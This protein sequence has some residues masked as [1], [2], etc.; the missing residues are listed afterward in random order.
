M[1]LVVGLLLPAT[2]HPQ[3]RPGAAPADSGSRATIDTVIILRQDLF[4]D[5]DEAGNAFF[6]FFN[7]LHTTTRPFVIERELLLGAG[8]P[9]DSLLAAES[10]RN[11]RRLGLFRSVR[12]DTGQV[13][14]RRALIVRTRDAWSL[15]PRATARI[16]ADGTLTGS[17]G[18]TETNLA[19][20]GNRLRVWYVREADRDGL[21]L[22]ASANRVGASQI[23]A[24]AAW[25]NLSD[26]DILRWAVARPFRSFSD[27]WSLHY[28]GRSF[29]GRV[30]QFRRES[31][32]ELETTE[33]RRHAFVNQAFATYAPV[34]NARE[35]VRVGASF[36]IRSEKYLKVE[37]PALDVDSIFAAV[38]D[39]V[40]GLIGGFVE[41]R[42]A[43]FARVRQFNGFS[44]EDQDLSDRAFMSLKLA[45]E[46][47]GYSST[48]VG[49]R[50]FLG[51]GTRVGR[52]ILKGVIDGS[53]LFNSAGL[54]SGLVVATATAAIRQSEHNTTFFQASG[55]LQESPRPGR[56]FDLGFERL[57]RLWGAHAFVGT[58]TFR[59]TVE[60]R[61]FALDN[62]LDLVGLGF[63]GF[64][65]YGGAWYPDQESRLGGNTGVS[66]FI[67]SPLGSFA[68]VS[69]V[70][71]GYRFGGGIAET[72]DSR[73]VLSLGA[74][75]VF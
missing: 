18:I 1:A 60:H 65:D 15:Q 68:Q 19:G 62:I 47:L 23:A 74:S 32:A 20:T 70:S 59:A 36:E 64:I 54:D 50:V 63:G 40:Y 53:A 38:P 57:P 75:I 34:A 66:V 48:G 31:P 35:Y 39:T 69:N 10:E 3:S 30:L 8:S 17:V 28:E 46:G 58:R 61:Y 12:V 6:R 14:G 22:Q 27:R 52:A 13:D 72:G 25:L 33:W 56:E 37:N 21:S 26:R 2:G 71:F 55:G 4:S 67:G 7:N 24:S 42:R 16:G 43:R 11:L 41:Y 44:E 5:E 49:A 45:H 51:S 73:W 29:E 9:F